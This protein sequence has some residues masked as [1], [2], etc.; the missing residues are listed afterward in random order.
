M[1][2]QEEFHYSP[3][4]ALQHVAAQHLAAEAEIYFTFHYA[5]STAPTQNLIS[6]QA[7]SQKRTATAT[8]TKAIFPF[9]REILTQNTQSL[10]IQA[11]CEQIYLRYTTQIYAQLPWDTGYL[12]LMSLSYTSQ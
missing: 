7:S 10:E 8:T 4:E 1:P 3:L 9:R 12:V 2:S 11:R 6:Q 5:N